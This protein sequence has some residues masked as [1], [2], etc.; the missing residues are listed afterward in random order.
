M[1]PDT[2]PQQKEKADPSAPQAD[3]L[4]LFDS[5]GSFPVWL[6]RIIDMLTPDALIKKTPP[7]KKE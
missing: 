4:G 3:E 5:Y 6:L 2:E 1:A 7:K